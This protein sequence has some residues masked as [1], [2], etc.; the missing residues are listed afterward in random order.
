MEISNMEKSNNSKP[1]LIV[2]A[3]MAGLACAK[4]LQ[5]AGIPFV[6]LEKESSGG[7]KVKTKLTD[8]GY[9]MDYGFQVLLTSYPELNSFINLDDLQ[10]KPFKSGCYIYL[11]GKINHLANPIMHPQHLFKEIFSDLIS[12]KDKILILKLIAVSRLKIPAELKQ[13]STLDFLCQ[14]GF[15]DEFI[16]IFWKPFMAGIF[17]DL[18]LSVSADFFL[19]LMKHFSTGRVAVPALGMQEIPLQILRSLNPGAIKFNSEVDQIA[20]DFVTL[21]SGEKID[22]RCV[23]VAHNPSTMPSDFHAVQNFYFTTSE[24]LNWGSWLVII[25]AE[26][27]LSISTIAIMNQVSEKYSPDK[28]SHLLSISVLEAGV[29]DI[30]KIKT[31]LRQISGLPLLDLKFI[32]KFQIKAA[33]PKMNSIQ[34]NGFLLKNDVFYCGDWA[35]SPSL[36]GALKSGRLVAEK[37]I[38]KC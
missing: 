17:L 1:V 11:D 24:N 7:G 19:F 38:S 20:K 14:F 23:V 22:G 31:E 9:R 18:K 36:N 3:G 32:E 16:N 21:K 33:L 27:G 12:V 6:V 10:M 26:T 2:G 37:I 30:E 8:Q 35:V 13:T 15:S 5:K 28:S 25:P 34:E 4:T 29:T